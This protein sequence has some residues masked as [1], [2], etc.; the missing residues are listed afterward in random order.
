M[1]IWGVTTSYAKK[2][3]N[4]ADLYC[5]YKAASVKVDDSHFINFWCGP[6][7]ANFVQAF[8]VN[9]STWEITTADI[10]GCT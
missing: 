3:I 9:T 8:A 10:M 5:Y 7:Y 6:G 2:G 4:L 1:A